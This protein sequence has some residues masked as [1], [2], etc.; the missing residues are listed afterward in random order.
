MARYH[1]MLTEAF[2]AL[3]AEQRELELHLVQTQERLATLA[4]DRSAIERLLPTLSGTRA[5]KREAWHRAQARVGIAAN[6]E[7][8]GR[9]AVDQ[10]FQVGPRRS[11]TEAALNAMVEFL[12]QANA[13]QTVEQIENALQRQASQFGTPENLRRFLNDLAYRTAKSNPGAGIVRR[14]VGRYAYVEG[15]EKESADD[16]IEIWTGKKSEAAPE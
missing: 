7:I 6:S 9:S 13:P 16:M 14:G 1:D 12:K 5:E 15:G 3:L 2:E 8:S 4:R 10:R 11:D